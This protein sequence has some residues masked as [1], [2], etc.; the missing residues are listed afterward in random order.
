GIHIAEGRRENKLVALL[1]QVA[2]DA[3]CVGPF[4]NVFNELGLDLIA[5]SL[6]HL[7]APDVLLPGPACL[8]DGTDIDETY[9]ER[10]FLG[11]PGGAGK[12]DRRRNGRGTQRMA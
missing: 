7:L 9:L 8:A 4:G 1:S 12:S 10:L 2:Y 11:R 3:L 5:Q 6:L